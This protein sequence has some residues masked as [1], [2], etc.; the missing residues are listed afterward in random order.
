MGDF[1]IRDMQVGENT[2]TDMRDACLCSQCINF[3]QNTFIDYIHISLHA[4][5]QCNG[6]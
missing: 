5:R 1:K 4:C 3:V 6:E 2:S